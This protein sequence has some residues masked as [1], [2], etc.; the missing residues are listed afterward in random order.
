[1]KPLL[2]NNGK[3][4]FGK[5]WQGRSYLL[6]N[7]FL[8]EL[9]MPI[10]RSIPTTRITQKEFKQ[11]SHEVMEHVFA[12][13]NEFGRFFDERVYKLELASRMEGVALE[14]SVTVTHGNFSKTYFIDALV[15][16]SGLFE[17]KTADSIHARHR[18]QTI[19]Y[20]LLC[21][22]AHGKIANM[23]TER[24][25]HEFVNCHQR[26]EKL[27]RPEIIDSEWRGQTPA[28]EALRDRVNALISDWG[29]GLE[30]GLYEEALTHALGGEESVHIPVPVFSSKGHIAYQSMRLA[31]PEVAFK[32]TALPERTDIFEAHMRKLLQHTSLAAV[33]WVNIT[34]Q[35]VTFTTIR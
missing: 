29:S 9:R 25:Q 24:V 7:T 35:T 23:R 31:S 28:C 8:P 19:N 27:R 21:D 5:R 12:I 30:I 18:G 34:H 6:Q 22:L 3:K 13:H 32:I 17:F 11:I 26:L 20:L 10:H 1:M 16:G 33:Q 14:P 4:M 2:M 15:H